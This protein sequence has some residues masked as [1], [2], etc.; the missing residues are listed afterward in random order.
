MV[1][2]SVIVTVPQGAGTEGHWHWLAGRSW[3][4]GWLKLKAGRGG[5]VAGSTGPEWAPPLGLRS[6]FFPYL[7]L[8]SLLTDESRLSTSLSLS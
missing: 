3:A 2:L 7:S 8:S 4:T 6:G 5:R 1:V